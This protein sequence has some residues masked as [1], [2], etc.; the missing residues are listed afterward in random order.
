MTNA[1]L[2]EDNKTYNLSKDDFENIYESLSNIEKN[3]YSKL[4]IL[5]QTEGPER[6]SKLKILEILQK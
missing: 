4:G 5:S 3:T 1:K 2:S 6:D